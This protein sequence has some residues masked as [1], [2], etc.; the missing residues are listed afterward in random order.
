MWKLKGNWQVGQN[1]RRNIGSSTTLVY[2]MLCVKKLKYLLLFSFWI[3]WILIMPRVIMH[4]RWRVA[5]VMWVWKNKLPACVIHDTQNLCSYSTWQLHQTVYLSPTLFM[6]FI[7]LLAKSIYL[8]IIDYFV[9]Y[10][11]VCNMIFFTY[12]KL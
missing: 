6:L 8:I 11:M 12:I 3:H 1:G 10:M 9:N 2:S 5:L 4:G 7:L